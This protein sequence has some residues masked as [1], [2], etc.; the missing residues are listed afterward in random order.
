MRPPSLFKIAQAMLVLLVLWLAFNRASAPLL[1]DDVWS[2]RAAMLPFDQMLSTLAADVHPPAYFIL[3]AAWVRIF[4]D[5]EIALRG[6]SILFYLLSVL[7]MYRLAGR[8]HGRDG[9]LLCAAVYSFT[10][11][12][13]L[14]ANLVRMY[15]LLSL[16]GI[17]STT[18]WVD[19]ALMRRGR[20]SDVRVWIAINILGT[21]C[22]LWFFCLLLGQSMVSPVIARRDLRKLIPGFALS[23]APYALLWFPSLVRQLRESSE[24]AAWLQPPDAGLLSEMLI[25]QFGLMA[26]ALPV[27]AF[28][29]WE[30]HDWRDLV[31]S[32]VLL[33]LAFV[34]LPPLLISFWKPFF[35]IRFT[36]VASHLFALTFGS[37]AIRYFDSRLTK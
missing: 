12:V 34:L 11:L 3:L 25:M 26:L 36:I 19:I 9:A 1:A 17:L 5:G 14:G 22:H 27:V 23:I 37:I 31:P 29:A 15:S 21:F 32:W 7:A 30:E 6:L 4:G 18:A 13:V 28:R 8:F 24:A 2:L 20:R 33:L 35:H 10:P 16:L